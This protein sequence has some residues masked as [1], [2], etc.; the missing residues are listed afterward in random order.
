MDC[1]EEPA[2]L[3]AMQQVLDRSHLWKPGQVGETVGT[4]MAEIGVTTTIYLVDHEQRSLR[5]LPEP[6]RKTPE[7]AAVDQ[8]LAGRAFALVRSYPGEDDGRARWWVPMVNGTDR[9]GVIDFLLPP[10][11]P[12]EAPRV[13]D[14]CEMF[15]GLVGHLITTCMPRGDELHRVRRSQPMSPASELLWQLLQPLTVATDELAVAAVLEPCYAVGGDGYDY[16]IDGHLASLAVLD[17]VGHGL[18]AGLATAV[19]LASIRAARRDGQDLSGQARAADAALFAEF[20]DA[21][22]VTAFLAEL[23]LRAGRLRHL[24]AG[25][26]APLLLRQSTAVA[27]ISG[28]RRLPLGLGNRGAQVGEQRLEPGDRLLLYTDGITEARDA[29]GKQFGRD[30]LIALAE[31]HTG[32]LPVPEA[33]RRLSHAVVEHQHGPPRDDATLLLA[34]WSPGAAR[35]VVP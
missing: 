7:P 13:R 19:A 4:V 33:V 34:E 20:P 9:L 29:D 32:S 16:A 28:G 31:Q 23:D 30:R 27:E 26:P 24:N 22:F 14:R 25:H 35:R 8:T 6:G 2:W 17:G 15:A 18:S 21:R 12:A 3:G 5:P 10:G 11:L 1:T